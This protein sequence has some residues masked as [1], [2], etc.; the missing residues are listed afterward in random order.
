MI[1]SIEMLIPR[2]EAAANRAAGKRPDSG[3][4]SD[5][6]WCRA[7]NRAFH[8]AMD[9]LT[10]EAGLRRMSYQRN[11]VEED[12]GGALRAGLD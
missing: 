9:E 5:G 8:L 3:A 7:W 2:A 11:G 12:G 1:P 6:G 4:R 10:F